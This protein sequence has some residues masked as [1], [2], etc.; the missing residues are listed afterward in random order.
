M[1]NY[2]IMRTLPISAFTDERKYYMMF[3]ACF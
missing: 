1:Y 2:A 3:K